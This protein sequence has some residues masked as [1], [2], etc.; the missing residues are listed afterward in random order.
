[1][2]PGRSLAELASAAL[3]CSLSN[4]CLIPLIAFALCFFK[5]GSVVVAV[6]ES[7]CR[8]EGRG[9]F[10]AVATAVVVGWAIGVGLGGCCCGWVLAARVFGGLVDDGMGLARISTV[11]RV[12]LAL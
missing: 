8:S 12:F 9:D 11:I 3:G 4:S 10:C 7:D 5:G 6:L 2:R 1:M